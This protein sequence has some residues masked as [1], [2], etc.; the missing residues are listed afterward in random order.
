MKLKLFVL[1]AVAAAITGC[2]TDASSDKNS[3]TLGSITLTGTATSGQTLT[4]SAND[5]DGISGQITYLWYADGDLIEGASGA[6]FTLTEDQVGSV[7]TAQAMY[8]DD[9]GVNESHISD[10]T[11]EVKA[12][13]YPATVSLNGDVT[14]GSTLSATVADQNGLDGATIIYSWFA[15]ET[16]ID[17]E[18]TSELTLTEAQFGSVITVN[19]SF[20]DDKGFAE[21][22]TSEGVGPVTRAN[23]VGEV[24]IQG[25][26]AVGKTLIADITDQDGVHGDV[27]YQWFA[28][29]QEIAGANSKSLVVDASL[30]GSKISVEVTYVDDN[31]FSENNLSNPTDEVTLVAADQAGSITISGTVPYMVDAVLTADI[32]DNNGV[33]EANVVYSWFADGVV[34]ADATEKT[35]TPANYAGAIISVSATYTDNDNFSATVTD[36]LSSVVYSQV[37]TDASEL[38]AAVSGGLTD[39]SVVG[40]NTNVY[41][42]IDAILLDS[43]VTLRAVEQQQPVISGETCIH[44]AANVDGAKIIGLTFKDIDTKAGSDCDT[45][46]QAVIYSEGDNFVFAQ[47]LIDGEQEDLNQSTYHWLVIKGH[48][49]MI[50]RNTFT[51]RTHSQKGSVIKLASSGSDH[52]VQYNLFSDSANENYDDSSLL[53][54]NV[55]ST[56]GSDAAL[57]SNI[58]ILNNRVENVVTGRRLMRVQTSGATIDGNTIVDANGGISLEDGGFNKVTNNII[59]RNTDVASSDDRP[60]GILVTP[61]GHTISNNYIAGIR[62]ENKEAGGIVF[63]ANPFSQNTGG[64][65]YDG[66]Q[67]IL[68]GTDDLTLTVNNNTVL[69]SIQ[70]IV[71][72]TEIGSKAPVGDCDELTS[73]NSPVL[74]GLTKNFFVINFDANLIANGLNE[75]GAIQGLFLPYDAS[76]SDHSFE[77]DCDLINHDNSYFSNNFGFSDSYASGDVED[78]FWV[79]IR[80][81]NGN[82]KFDSDGAIDQNPAANGKEAPEF[83]VADNHLTETDPNGAQAA[84]GAKGLHVIQASEVGVGST[85]VAN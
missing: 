27:A 44:I 32:A 48:G 37:V 56:T 69:N 22:V 19:V 29:S 30:V 7:I 62:S 64:V 57:N 26:P 61:L 36:S 40:L 43:S 45:S 68:D 31:G 34:I 76:S 47:N 84:A 53:L 24:V 78:D 83:V 70:P 66:N 20:D 75:E 25:T 21:S 16:P 80:N 77:Y 4:A 13:A 82:G 49:A 5:A 14:I 46:E 72:S 10:A 38:S 12:I 52:V 81:E 2:N 41:A 39:G 60:S 58:K 3:N 1:C 18:V 42:D 15:D 9:G 55:G 6:S 17:G 85:W 71:F 79:D 33:E 73:D 35:F 8:T 59:I 23:T 28:D 74:Y 50:E 65:P 51:H 67:A 63:T 11:S 54:L